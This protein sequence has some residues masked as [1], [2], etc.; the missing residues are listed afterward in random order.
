VFDVTNQPPAPGAMTTMQFH[1]M[2]LLVDDQAITCEAIRR[3]I[4]G[5]DDIDFH[6]CPNPREATAVAARVRPTVILQDLIMPG[7][8]G[9][10]LLREYRNNPVTRDI[11]IIVLSTKEDPL[12]KGQAFALGANDYLV[13]LP[14]SIELVARIRYHTKAFLSMAQRDAAY[15]ALRDS[16]QQLLEANSALV[17]LNQKLEEATQAKSQ[18]LANMSHEIRTPMNGVLGMCSLLLNTTLTEEQREYAEAARNSADALLTIIN[19]IL[20]FSKIE[21]GKLE[22]EQLP[23]ELHTCIEDA[24]D[25]LSQ[26]AAEKNLDIAYLIHEGVPRTLVSDSTRV[27]QILI[28]LISNAVKFTHQGEVVVEVT[29]PGR[30]PRTIPIGAKSDTDFVRHPELWRLHF[31]VKDTGIGIPKEKQSR[32]FRSFE[33]VDA[34]TARK[35]GGTGLGLAISKRLVELLGGSIWVESSEG[36]GATFHFTILTK[37]VASTAAA[38]QPRPLHLPGKRLLVIDDNATNRRVLAHHAAH[39]GMHTESAPDLACAEGLLKNGRTFDAY[40]VDLQLPNADPL[41]FVSTL[42]QSSAGRYASVLLLSNVGAKPE[43]GH[44]VLQAIAATIHK[45]IHQAQLL[46][47]FGTAFRMQPQRERRLV[48]PPLDPQLAQRLPL[49]LLLADD[50]PINQKVGQSVLHKLGYQADLANNGLEALRAVQRKKYDIVFLDVQM[51]EMDGL[52]TARQICR[53]LP[54]ET[55]PFI[56]AMTGN[57][58]SGDREKCLAAGMHDYICKPV[59]IADLQSAIERWGTARASLYKIHFP[60]YYPTESDDSLDLSILDE[61]K[62]LPPSEGLGMLEELLGLFMDS[63]PKRIQQIRDSIQDAPRLAFHAHA[64]KSMGLHLG[65]KKLVSIA[66]KLERCGQSKDLAQVPTLVGDLEQAY[67][68]T[69]AQ[70]ISYRDQQTTTVRQA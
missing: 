16:Q 38:S 34:S 25:L 7:M 47:A 43:E 2:V 61:L 1:A 62:D 22:L 26:R 68:R 45:P 54:P 49:D 14:D 66:Q 41:K 50:N 39:C 4:A 37:A 24:L 57:A 8:D 53:T 63:A 23:F 32:L 11:P 59:R 13:K 46:D 70:L 58:F 17:S 65:A 56:I 21:S 55:R 10:T 30:T 67:T 18:F 52:E 29:A 60:G 9:L 40:I 44:P 35:Y 20:D 69:E 42:R 5:H 19:D 6:F 28:N 48:S 33:Q 36:N 64:L 3:A 15:Q 31:S 27:K 51:P 12:I